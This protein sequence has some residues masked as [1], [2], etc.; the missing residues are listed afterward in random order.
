[1]TSRDNIVPAF[2]ISF[3]SNVRLWIPLV[4]NYL[5]KTAR[6]F[7]NCEMINKKFATLH[8]SG[9][10]YILSVGIEHFDSSILMPVAKDETARNGI[11][12]HI[13]IQ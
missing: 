7:L 12:N 10:K 8:L 5:P 4:L 6:I 13:V 1:M 2:Y 9:T 3:R 11:H